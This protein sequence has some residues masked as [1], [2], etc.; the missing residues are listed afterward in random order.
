M[1]KALDLGFFPGIGAK[2]LV[3]LVYVENV[4]LGH[5]LLEAALQVCLLLAGGRFFFLTPCFVT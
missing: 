1:E 3:D 4:V 5:V 2:A